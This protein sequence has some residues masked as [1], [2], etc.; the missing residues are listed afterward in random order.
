MMIAP[1]SH[2]LQAVYKVQ[3]AGVLQ[4]NKTSYWTFFNSSRKC[5]WTSFESNNGRMWWMGKKIKPSK[6]ACLIYYWFLSEKTFFI[7]IKDS[8]EQ[9]EIL[10]AKCCNFPLSVLAAACSPKLKSWCQVKIL[11]WEIFTHK[12]IMSLNLT[13]F[14]RSNQL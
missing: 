2:L 5:S 3:M 1:M 14:H 6:D 10:T 7:A 12:H 4:E 13:V 8:K 9:K 11:A